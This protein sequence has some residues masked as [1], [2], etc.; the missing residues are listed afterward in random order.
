MAPP[1]RRR[2]DSLPKA[3]RS[4]YLIIMGVVVIMV[5][6]IMKGFGSTIELV[7]KV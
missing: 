3:R 2:L 5:I 1:Y 6:V 7:F 4:R